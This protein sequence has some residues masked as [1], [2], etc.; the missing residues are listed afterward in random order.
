VVFYHKEHP[1]EYKKFLDDLREKYDN[2]NKTEEYWDF[3]QGHPNPYGKEFYD[4]VETHDFIKFSS[5]P[6]IAKLEM[7]EINYKM[8]TN[9]NYDDVKT[10]P[11][12][13]STSRLILELF[14][15]LLDGI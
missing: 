10:L 1:E 7:K 5:N 3:V 8:H 13:K 11:C 15:S 14:V 4:Y 2:D 12:E 9:P 6:E